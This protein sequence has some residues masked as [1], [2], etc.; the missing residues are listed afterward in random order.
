MTG[1]AAP[2][3]PGVLLCFLVGLPAGLDVEL[4][5]RLLGI[6]IALFALLPF[7]LLR[8][9]LRFEGPMRT[10]IILALLWCL[11]QFISD[12]I[13]QSSIENMARGVA[14]AVMTAV[15][16]SA[17]FLLIKHSFLNA[18]AAFVGLGVGLI[19]G[20]YFNPLIYVEADPWKFAYGTGATMLMIA[21]ATLL[22]DLRWRGSAIMLCLLLC[23][24]N[25]LLGFRSMGGITFVAALLLALS[26]LLGRRSRR[27]SL[28][29]VATLCG[30]LVLGGAGVIELYA[31]AAERGI[32]GEHEQEKFLMQVGERGV[33]LSGRREALVSLQAIMDR[34]LFGHGSWATNEDYAIQFWGLLGVD[35]DNIPP[36]AD[37][38]IPTHS[39][40]FGAWVEGGVFAAFFW[41]YVLVLIGRAAMIVVYNSGLIDPITAFVLPSL[42]WAIFFSPYGFVDRPTSTF[43]IVVAVM[44]LHWHGRVRTQEP[45]LR[46]TTSPSAA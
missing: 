6:E 36:D 9:R 28:M 1:R 4:I 40:L 15:L 37:D 29:R 41:M 26:M 5:G 13:N 39:Y 20:G 24:L 3:G 25:L 34:P 35:V 8:R 23:G 2:V 14:R 42:G 16:L 33:L 18:F 10:L 46:P 30:V 17:F 27:L 31:Q 44:V 12:I 11:A 7:L 22:W 45:P 32:L 43:G 19:L 21:V 38:L